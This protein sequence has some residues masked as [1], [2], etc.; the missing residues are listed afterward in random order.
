MAYNRAKGTANNDGTLIATPTRTGRYNEA[1]V[2]PITNKELFA[3]D[4]GSQFVAVNPTMGTG[5]IGHAAATTFDEAKA[6]LVIYNGNTAA[7]GIYVYPQ[8]ILLDVTVVGVGHTRDQFSFT[9]DSGNRV[10]S[11]GT[12]LT[13]ANVNMDSATT[14]GAV[15]T[16]GAV[17]STAATAGRRLLGNY[18]V[19]GAN[20]EVVWDQF[21]FIFGSP[22]GSTGG[23]LTP[24]TVAAHFTRY[25]PPVVIG[26]GESLCVH[27]WAASQSTGITF[28]PVINYI[29]R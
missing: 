4:E 17:V 18:V 16:F 5:I 23:L 14:S 6:L 19:R 10:S 8:S 21:E 11:A 12:A 3:A 25:L 24:T 15:V 22:G 7:S 2:N 29:E 1:Y 20:I 13:K 26:P 27:Q 28:E 9:L